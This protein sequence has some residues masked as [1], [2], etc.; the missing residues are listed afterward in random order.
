MVLD[1]TI[2]FTEINKSMRQGRQAPP[3][4]HQTVQL[5]TH[6]SPFGEITTIKERK[7][8]LFPLLKENGERRL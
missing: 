7:T 2:L 3:L 4:L 6:D 1:V 8:A 5:E